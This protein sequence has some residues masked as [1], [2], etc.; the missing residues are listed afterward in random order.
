VFEVLSVE[1]KGKKW[2][3]YY[4]DRLFEKRGIERGSRQRRR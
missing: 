1:G 3:E 2:L 4:F